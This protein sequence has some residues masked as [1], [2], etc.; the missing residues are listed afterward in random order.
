MSKFLATSKLW[1][2][3]PMAG[4]NTAMKRMREK[5]RFIKKTCFL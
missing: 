4:T 5:I 2:C 3:C 1:S